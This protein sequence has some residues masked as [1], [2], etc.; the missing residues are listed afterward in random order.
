MNIKNI[1]LLLPPHIW[2]NCLTILLC[3]SAMS[4]E[5][6]T[7]PDWS[8]VWER[9]EGNG[10]MFDIATT[11]PPEGRAGSPGVRQ[12]PPLTDF[13]EK[14]YT[15]NID[16]VAL[17]RLPDPISVCGTPA[18]YPRLLALPDVYE[19]IV[20][21]EKTWI[22]TE[23]GPNI[24]RIY[25]DGRALPGINERW[26]T[27]TGESVGSW[28]QGVLVFTTV[29]MIGEKN[30]VLDRSGLTLSDQ[31][32][33]FTRMF[34]NEEGLLRAE[35]SITDPIALTKPWN[36]IRHFRKL[37]PGTRIFD[38]ACAENNRNPITSSGKTLTLGPD[39]VPIDIN[40]D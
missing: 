23:N 2:I 33:I 19:F 31:A 29:S 24:M 22:I 26:P 13:W 15:Q 20:R 5:I 4:Q 32:E 35:L 3:S 12:F 7:L 40:F 16:L 21:E 37:P 39:G 27:Y 28:D 18:G 36:V 30:T 14:K 1:I 8:G 38:Y 9:Y 25:T 10:G 11:Q 34:L 17:D 6:K